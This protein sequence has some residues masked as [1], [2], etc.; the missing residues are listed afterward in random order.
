[1]VKV[2]R[3]VTVKL[4]ADTK[5]KLQHLS[6][7][8]SR[9]PHWLM[10]KAI[11]DYVEKEERIEKLKEETLA[12]WKEAECGKVIPHDEVVEWLG[13]WGTSCEKNRP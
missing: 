10:K 6:K 11:D 1:M 13:N 8:K 3:I 5:E 2:N 12:R 4:E 9:S 7:L